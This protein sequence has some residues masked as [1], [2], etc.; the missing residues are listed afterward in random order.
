MDRANFGVEG[1]LFLVLGVQRQ[2]LPS[3]QD[4]WDRRVPAT[5]SSRWRVVVA[6][7]MYVHTCMM[8]TIRRHPDLG[9]TRRFGRV[10]EV[11]L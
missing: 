3:D 1:R 4:N 9:E 11:G 8:D 2:H 7:G 5:I 10:D 6:D